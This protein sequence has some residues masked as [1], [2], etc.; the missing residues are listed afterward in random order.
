MLGRVVPVERPADADLLGELAGAH[1]RHGRRDPVVERRG[2]PGVVAAARGPRHPDPLRIDLGAR[3]QVLQRAAGLILGEPLLG[4]PDQQRLGAAVVARRDAPLPLAE[5]VEAE[6][7]EAEPGHV[8]AEG[9]EVRPGLAVGPPVAGVEQDGR[10]GAVESLG[11]VQMG[12]DRRARE[13][14]VD[15]LL[16]PVSRRAGGC[17][18]RAAAGREARAAVRRRAT[19]P[20]PAAAARALRSA[21]RAVR[22]RGI[23]ARASRAG[24]RGCRASPLP[25]RCDRPAATRPPRGAGPRHARHPRR[26]RSGA[27]SSPS[28]VRTIGDRSWSRPS[29]PGDARPGRPGCAGGCRRGPPGPSRPTRVPRRGP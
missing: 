2:D 18:R 14:V 5:R 26:R 15:H 17:R 23:A 22:D 10:R 19:V 12:R 27:R 21:S 7:D 29:N 25:G 6:H 8:D 16:D 11:D 24:A 4:D 28:R 13:G 3:E 1:H 9:L 20:A